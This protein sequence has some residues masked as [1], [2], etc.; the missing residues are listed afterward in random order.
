MKNGDT[1]TMLFHL[2]GCVSEEKWKIINVDGDIV[3]LDTDEDVDR[4][5]KFNTKTGECIND[6]TTFGARRTLKI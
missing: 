5:R 1:V 2:A 4:C 3:T 6:D